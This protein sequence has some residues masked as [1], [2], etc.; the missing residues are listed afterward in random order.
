M[1]K[2]LLLSLILFITILSGVSCVSEPVYIGPQY[3]FVSF[4]DEPEY[5]NR[6]TGVWNTAP[7]NFGSYY[8][9]EFRND[10]SGSTSSYYRRSD[11]G[12]MIQRSPVDFRYKVS[13]SQIAFYYYY[14]DSANCADY[15]ITG[16][17][18]SLTNAFRGSLIS[19]Y[20]K[21][22]RDPGASSKKIITDEEITAAAEKKTKQAVIDKE[23]AESASF[24]LNVI[25]SGAFNETDWVTDEKI[26]MD[27]LV[28]DTHSL[29]LS[30][31]LNV[32]KHLN[33]GLDL[34]IK[35]FNVAGK[36]VGFT[37]IMNI[38]GLIGFKWASISLD[39]RFMN[40]N[41]TFPS[42]KDEKKESVAG[43]APKQPYL[44]Y[45]EFSR[46]EARTVA[47]MFST[48]NYINFGLIWANATG[49]SMV[50]N[51]YFDP[52]VET[53]AFGIR[54][55]LRY[56]YF[57]RLASGA[58]DVEPGMHFSFVADLFVDLG[59]G[60]ATLSSDVEKDIK[61]DPQMGD[62]DLSVMY[63]G[64]RG[65]LGV[66][67]VKQLEKRNQYWEIIG[68]G[69]DINGGGTT[70]ADVSFGSAVIGAFVRMGFGF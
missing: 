63:N 45:D 21:T 43:I 46:V 23:A 17:N 70:A 53:N 62:L 2:L 48:F 56:D 15:A 39:W 28:T 41:A 20:Q 69:L 32:F 58:I 37:D 24:M 13:N 18:L 60:R 52:N 6:F 59:F 38:G 3:D 49:A 8:A 4:Q 36:D 57:S 67:V 64:V 34:G 9:V 27:Y 51:K 30:M 31:G 5:R 16:N 22:G 11:T 29:S 10:G 12:E 42:T 35:D 26:P 19:N 7:D 65:M 50:Q 66:H 40:G 44:K 61:D 1:K 55:H 47:L 68:A 25:Y 33:L 54:A 14:N